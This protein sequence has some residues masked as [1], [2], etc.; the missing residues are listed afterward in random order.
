M[1]RVDGSYEGSVDVTPSDTDNVTFPNG[2]SVSKAIYVDVTGDVKVV[3]AD[4]TDALFT[5][6]P[7]AMFHPLAV[8][9]V[10]STGTTATGIK[11]LY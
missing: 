3:M 4:G 2:T 6:L 7:A 8:K 9:R 11:A 1:I 10:Y 5:A